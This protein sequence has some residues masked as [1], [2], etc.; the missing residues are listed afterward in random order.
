M[1]LVGGVHPAADQ[2]FR[3][4]AEVDWSLFQCHFPDH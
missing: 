4:F 3:R 1:R 2:G